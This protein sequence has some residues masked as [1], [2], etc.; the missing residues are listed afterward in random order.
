MLSPHEIVG[1]PRDLGRSEIPNGESA[2][3]GGDAG[4][5]TMVDLKTAE[6]KLE[7]IPKNIFSHLTKCI[8]ARAKVRAQQVLDS[9]LVWHPTESIQ[10][11]K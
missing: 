9:I 6:F 10:R 11:A 8:V 1:D 5:E 7:P 3:N 4:P 2:V